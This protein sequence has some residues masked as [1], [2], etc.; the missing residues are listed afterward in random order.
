M[1]N[2]GWGAWMFGGVVL[3]VAFW[4]LLFWAIVSLVRRPARSDAGSRGASDV[5]AER[6]ARGEIDASEYESRRASLL[7]S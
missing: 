2:G 4:G 7:G 3:M 6:F 1:M 5:L